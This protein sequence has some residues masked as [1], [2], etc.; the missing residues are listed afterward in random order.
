[1]NNKPLDIVKKNN[2]TISKYPTGFVINY[3]DGTKEGFFKTDKID[4][5]YL[6]ESL[7][8]KIESVI[9]LALGLTYF[10]TD[11]TVVKGRSMQP[12]LRYGQVI[13]KSK[14]KA[15]VKKQLLQ[16]GII[17]KFVSPDGDVS[18]KRIVGVPGD[19]VTLDTTAVYVNDKLLDRLNTA[20]HPM[21]NYQKRK[22]FD[23]GKASYLI[24]YIKLKDSEFFVMG[25]NK[26]NSIDSRDYGPIHSES[27][28][29]IIG[30]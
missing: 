14:A 22:Y 19:T 18:I 13:I 8:G 6:S 28:L 1:M 26:D 16:K 2:Y 3:K 21:P 7:L 27:I 5:T 30:K 11:V 4:E 20:D 29:S 12:A 9:I 15:E 23:K 25:D 24:D 17:I 10:T